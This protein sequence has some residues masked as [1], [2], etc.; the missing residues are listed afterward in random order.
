MR[1]YNFKKNKNIYYLFYPFFNLSSLI[2]DEW[3]K[4]QTKG[5]GEGLNQ[6]QNHQIVQVGS[7]SHAL[8][9]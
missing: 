7:L 9:V 6:G 3:E 1:K 2:Y 4:L 8:S 5:E